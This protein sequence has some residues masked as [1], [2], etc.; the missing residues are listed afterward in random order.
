[1]TQM[2]FC[3]L[4]T[5]VHRK[6]Q[7]CLKIGF[8]LT[9]VLLRSPANQS[10]KMNSTVCNFTKFKI[11]S[12]LRASNLLPSSRIF[13]PLHF[14]FSRLKDISMQWNGINGPL[15]TKCCQAFDRQ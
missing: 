1:M 5:H 2:R 9:H 10:D 8:L 4:V 15:Y 7:C 12:E 3:A 14:A 11:I 13:V 6:E